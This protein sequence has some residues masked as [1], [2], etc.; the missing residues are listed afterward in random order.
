MLI[1]VLSAAT[2][3]QEK[4]KRM[5]EKVDRY[6]FVEICFVLKDGDA[7]LKQECE[8]MLPDHRFFLESEKVIFKK[9]LPNGEYYL[10]VACFNIVK[11]DTVIVPFELQ[12][13]DSRGF[14]IRV[15][16]SCVVKYAY[17]FTGNLKPG[18]ATPRKNILL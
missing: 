10:T 6:D 15:D 16:K 17:T 14:M 2:F 4:P 18:N 9:P 11:K 12:S 13:F 3:A 1:A 7:H 8:R 5:E